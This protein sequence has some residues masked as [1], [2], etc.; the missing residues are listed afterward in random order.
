MAR[1]KDADRATNRPLFHPEHLRIAAEVHTKARRRRRLNLSG[2]LLPLLTMVL[3]ALLPV[4][5]LAQIMIL[6]LGQ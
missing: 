5:M 1:P 4:F 6:L 2:G 3:G